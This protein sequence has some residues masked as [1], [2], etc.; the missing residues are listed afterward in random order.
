M[1]LNKW[2]GIIFVLKIDYSC[3]SAGLEIITLWSSR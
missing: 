1:H 3:A 2:S